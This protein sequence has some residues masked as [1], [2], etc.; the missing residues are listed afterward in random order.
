M[1]AARWRLARRLP[2]R[3]APRGRR[4]R[5]RPEW[6]V[7]RGG[8]GRGL[9]AA[10]RVER[11]SLPLVLTRNGSAA[12]RGR[13]LHSGLLSIYHDSDH[14]P[15]SNRLRHLS[16][17]LAVIVFA[18]IA[19]LVKDIVELDAVGRKFV[20]YLAVC[21]VCTTR[22]AASFKFWYGLRFCSRTV[23]FIKAN[24]SIFSSE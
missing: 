12:R 8:G 18:L 3:A 14:L 23:V 5:Q 16:Y 11:V 7:I 24:T 13:H 1:R 22:M 6:V 9:A 20:L 10:K 21:C 17:P 15:R 4:R 2:A 19:K